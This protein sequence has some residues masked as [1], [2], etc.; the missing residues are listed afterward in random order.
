M[1]KWIY[2]GLLCMAVCLI[3]GCSNYTY[4]AVGNNNNL[5]KYSTFAWL[6]PV[7]NTKNPYYDNDLADQKIK[8]QATFDLESKGLHLKA[9]RPD[10]LV[11]YTIMVDKKV[12]V[13]NEPA[14]TYT[15][16]GYYPH[17]RYYRG[18]AFYYYSYRG[19]YP[20]YLGENV[21]RVPYK[22][23]TLI[24][25]LI[26]RATHKVIWRGYGIGEVTDPER[27]VNDLPKVVDGILNKLPLNKI[28]R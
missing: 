18:H 23:G 27:A 28:V 9:R 14:Y 20:V 16:G 26:D 15:W 3:A 17:I 7:N 13:Y 6:A 25:D 4:Y 22:E 10:L 8:D 12:K 11:R 2:G 24:I 1:K 5:A 19:S 21:Y